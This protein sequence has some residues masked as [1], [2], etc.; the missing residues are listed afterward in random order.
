MNR[1]GLEAHKRHRRPGQEEEGRTERR[2][3]PISGPKMKP[4]S[5]E[6]QQKTRDDK[7]G[8]LQAAV[9]TEG[10]SAGPS[11]CRISEGAPA[12]PDHEVVLEHRQ[13][14]EDGNEEDG[15]EHTCERR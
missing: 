10:E 9:W 12:D 5:E 2:T 7:V 4:E 6:S 15:T 11:A 1:V 8:V 13:P 14:D 3:A